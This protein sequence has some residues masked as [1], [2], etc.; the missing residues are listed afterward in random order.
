[1]SGNLPFASVT[2]GSS[3]AIQQNSALSFFTA[4]AHTQRYEERIA[5]EHFISNTKRFTN[6]QFI[7]EFAI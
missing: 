1:M 7:V 6:D 4:K 5:E 2:S 3:L